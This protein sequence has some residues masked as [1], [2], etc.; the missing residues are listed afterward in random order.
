MK[1]KMFVL[2]LKNE[3][4]KTRFGMFGAFVSCLFDFVEKLQFRNRNSNIDFCSSPV[5]SM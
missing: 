2:T 5:D 1:E 3:Q 4:V